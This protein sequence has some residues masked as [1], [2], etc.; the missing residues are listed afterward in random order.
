MDFS[1]V[2]LRVSV[3]SVPPWLW[4]MVAES[5]NLPWH[6]DRLLEIKVCYSRLDCFLLNISKI[7]RLK[8]DTSELKPAAIKSLAHFIAL[9][10]KTSL[11]LMSQCLRP[12]GRQS[13]GFCSVADRPSTKLCSTAAEPAR[14]S[15][16][17]IWW[18]VDEQ[19]LLTTVLQNQ[20]WRA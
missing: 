5:W 14:S 13:R 10:N 15:A 16:F 3:V 8:E 4:G 18:S 11:F 19:N 2:V 7:Y 17:L 12:L 1:L 20:A 6:Q 9:F